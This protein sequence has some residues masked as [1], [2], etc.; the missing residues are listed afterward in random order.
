MNKK[1]VLTKEQKKTL[2]DKGLLNKL[3]GNT[4]DRIPPI[5]DENGHCTGF[6]P[7]ELKTTRE[8]D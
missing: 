3:E 7:K 5:I 8:G 2:N 4:I 1:I 6:K